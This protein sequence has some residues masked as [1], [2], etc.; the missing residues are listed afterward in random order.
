MY[1][2]AF[3]TKYSST[4]F[5]FQSIWRKAKSVG[6][7]TKY[8]TKD[9]DPENYRILRLII[10]VALLPENLIGEG[11]AYVEKL[12]M[13][14]GTKRDQEANKNKAQK[15]KKNETMWKR[16]FEYIH[17]TWIKRFKTHFFCVFDS[18]KRT[19]NVLE[20]LHRDYN[21]FFGGRPG[22]NKFV[23]K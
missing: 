7:W 11:L 20:R 16:M 13:D 14:L 3:F 23:S 19:N 21:D 18:F 6:L 15:R 4:T 8:K 22:V 10:N 9:K 5:A 1:I 2:P 17:K 12:A